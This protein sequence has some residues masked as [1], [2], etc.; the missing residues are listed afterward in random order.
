MEKDKIIKKTIF[1]QYSVPKIVQNEA[2]SYSLV[3]WLY[4]YYIQ[5]KNVILDF[6]KCE[7]ISFP[8]LVFLKLIN[9][10][11][12]YLFNTNIIN[13]NVDPVVDFKFLLTLTVKN[14]DKIKY[15][16]L[17]NYSSQDEETVKKDINK[18]EKYIRNKDF[19][20]SMRSVL[21]E[22]I[23]NVYTHS[24]DAQDYYNYKM[25]Y[26]I[27]ITQKVIGITIAN[28][29]K[30]M[31]DVICGKGNMIYDR[32]FKYLNKACEYGFSTKKEGVG[33]LGL[34]T[35]KNFVKKYNA[36]LDIISGKGFVRKSYNSENNNWEDEGLD[37]L[38]KLPG[39]MFYIEI[40]KQYINR[41]N[42][43]FYNNDLL[44]S[45]MIKEI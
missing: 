44:E 28:N 30:L 9:D 23:I 1:S 12:K 26:G 42:N 8:I 5:R 38:Y 18:S 45:I 20:K 6:S 39:T 14:D 41:N 16:F 35:I 36:T 2:D 43:N 32:D 21:H 19:F 31:P 17:N 37:L 3:E 27:I 7:Y 24:N 22:L 40:N 10:K 4:R 11:S 34:F 13:Y 25:Y 15:I 33:G 29:G